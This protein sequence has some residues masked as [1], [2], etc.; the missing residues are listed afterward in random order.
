MSRVTSRRPLVSVIIPTYNSQQTISECIESLMEQEYD[1]IEVIVVDGG[2]SDRTLDICRR[3]NTSIIKSELGMAASRVR[4]AKEAKGDFLF[5]VDSDMELSPH[6]IDECVDLT[7][8]FEALIIPE[9]NVGDSYWAE[10]TDIGKAISRRKKT[11]HLRFLK[12]DLYESVG[13][14]NPHLLYKEDL[15]LHE[16]VFRT[17]ATIGHTHNVIFHNIGDPSLFDILSQKI[18][19][20]K[21]LSAYQDNSRVAQIRSKND[22]TSPLI[23]IQELARRPAYAPG[24]IL[25]TL[26]SALLSQVFGKYYSLFG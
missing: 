1:N 14:H 4:G 16:L 15:E 7:K 5:H 8:D 26:L 19:Y 22:E 18:S 11:G 21:S 17:G 23:L 25:I 3:Y 10:C 20:F 6:L 9:I 24:Y 12:S 13:G 2:S